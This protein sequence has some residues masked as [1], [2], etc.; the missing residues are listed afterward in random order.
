MQFSLPRVNQAVSRVIQKYIDIRLYMNAQIQT[1]TYI[2]RQT[3]TPITHILRCHSI[4][5]NNSAII[6]VYQS[7]ENRNRKF[8]FDAYIK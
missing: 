2:F 5:H 8:L 1:R 7:S 4:L 3:R 6:N